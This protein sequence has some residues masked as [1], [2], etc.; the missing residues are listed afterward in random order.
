MKMNYILPFDNDLTYYGVLISCGLILG[1]SLYYWIKS[2]N[3]AI[4]S[5]NMEPLTNE[6]LEAIVNENA[7]AVTLISSEN[8]DAIIDSESDTD[9]TSDYQSTTDTESTLD[10]D[11]NELDLFFM[12]NV[13]F[14]VCS[15]QEL[16]HFE[17]S[18]IFSRELLEHDINDEELTE[19]LS[20]FTD[21]QLLTNS[22]N[23]F[24]LWIILI[25]PP[26]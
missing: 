22:I 19:L 20:L 16:K 1:C 9:T 5:K 17:I 8:I 25:I 11:I 3:T 23:D 6:E 7:N 18:S 26:L 2:N 21:E 12:P 14:N 10:V 15:I 13:D 4:P 24:I